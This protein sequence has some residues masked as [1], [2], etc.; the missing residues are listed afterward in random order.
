[1]S[2]RL[3]CAVAILV[4]ASG[5]WTYRGPKGVE[6]ALHDSFG[7]DLHREVGMKLGPISLKLVGSFAGDD[8]DLHGVTTLGFAVYEREGSGTK[9]F[10][11]LDTSRFAGPEW[12]RMVD[13]HDGDDQVVV[14]AKT[15]N[16][17]IHEMMM[18]SVDND[19]IVVARLT[20]HLD[21]LI[22]KTMDAA[23]NDGPRAARHELAFPN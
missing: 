22:K 2:K 7:S 18:V 17:S 6:A 4:A 14:L 21:A 11:P 9:P 16:G 13:A 15:R 12:S 23:K 20:G 1:M 8:I 19:E 5:C 10:R 3:A